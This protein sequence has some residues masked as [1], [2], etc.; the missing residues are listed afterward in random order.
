MS[1]PITKLVKKYIYIN[2]IRDDLFGYQHAT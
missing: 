2:G 1:P